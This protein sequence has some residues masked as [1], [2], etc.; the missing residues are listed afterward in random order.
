[1]ADGKFHVVDLGDRFVLFSGTLA[2]CERVQDEGYGGL[3]VMDDD[4]LTDLGLTAQ[5]DLN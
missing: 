1:M 5:A 2:E 4:A 3:V